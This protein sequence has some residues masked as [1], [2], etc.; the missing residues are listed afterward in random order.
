MVIGIGACLRDVRIRYLEL[1]FLALTTLDIRPLN[2]FTHSVVAVSTQNQILI[3]VWWGTSWFL[4]FKQAV[5]V[6]ISIVSLY[7]SIVPN[8]W[9]LF[10]ISSLHDQVSS[11]RLSN[12]IWARSFENVLVT[13]RSLWGLLDHRL[14]IVTTSCSIRITLYLILILIWNILTIKHT[15]SDLVTCSGQLRACCLEYGRGEGRI[16]FLLITFHIKFIYF[17]I[18]HLIHSLSLS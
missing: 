3:I 13:I 6:H 15:L 7:L 9:T 1:P 5:N 18:N 11:Y 17:N 16:S 2:G 10:L 12:R 14:I 8:S 4:S